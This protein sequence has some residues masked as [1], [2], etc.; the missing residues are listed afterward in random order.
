MTRWLGILLLAASA[1]AADSASSGDS[2]GGGVSFGGQQ[3]IGEFRGILETG[4]L[5][6][7]DT[8]DA[9]GFFNEH[10]NAPPATDCTS[11]LCLTPGVSVGRDWLTG[12]HQAT[13]Q[14]AVNTNVDPEAIVRKP[15]N[16]VVVVDHSG[17]L[18]DDERLEKVKVGLHQLV[19][20]LG[21]GDRLAL[22]EFDDTVDVLAPLA[23]TTN[24]DELHAI[25]SQLTPRGA[26][27]IYDGLSTGLSLAA[28]AFSSDRQN[29]VIFLSDGMATAGNTSTPAI[30]S[31]TDGYIERGIGLTTIGV[32]LSFDVSMMRGLA[33][34][35]AGNFYFL[36]DAEAATEVFQ[37]ELD[38][39]VT[40]LALDV[41]IK[42]TAGS[43]WTFG[44]VIG[45]SMWTSTPSSGTVAIPAVFVASRTSQGPDPGRRGGG[46]MLFVHLEPTG[47][48]ADGKVADLELTYRLPGS[49]EILTQR[50]TL[51]YPNDPSETPSETYLSAPEMAERFAMYNTFLGLRFATRAYNYDCAAAALQSTRANAVTWNTTHEDPDITADL[52]LIDLY[53]ANLRA[54]GAN[55]ES[56]LATCGAEN[57]YGDDVYDGGLDHHYA[58]SASGNPRGLVVIALAGALA[59]RRRRRA[60]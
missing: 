32:G 19:D 45:S 42:A 9:N 12:A 35:G 37:Q 29:R 60:K 13:L 27:N 16:L 54:S 8:L 3:D 30:I 25:I 34:H 21:E 41:Q 52:E 58:C 53:L 33:E 46:S 31:M 23:E 55:S 1:C 24:K 57:P 44:E 7:P 28:E 43:G 40:P 59:V 39:F 20:S 56:A 14:I 4:G 49:S 50:I 47:S 5:P 10:Y 26:T 51:A 15:L 36:E 6:G 18:W 48:N 11:V 2:S 22:V 38:Y 17:S